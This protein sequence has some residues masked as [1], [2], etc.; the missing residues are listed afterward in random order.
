MEVA[1]LLNVAND[2]LVVFSHGVVLDSGSSVLGIDD[3]DDLVLHWKPVVSIPQF[4]MITDQSILPTANESVVS[5]SEES[6]I[7]VDSHC[8]G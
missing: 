8:H 4:P 6:L 3:L 5:Q 2:S 7:R 1:L